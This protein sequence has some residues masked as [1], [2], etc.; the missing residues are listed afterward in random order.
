LRVDKKVYL[1]VSFCSISGTNSPKSFDL[2]TLSTHYALHFASPEA[3]SAWEI[4]YK[5]Q[6]DTLLKNENN[7]KG[8]NLNIIFL[9]SNFVIFYFL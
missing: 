6:L 3:K 2:V 7:S 8:L 4:D 5:S 1:F 9:K